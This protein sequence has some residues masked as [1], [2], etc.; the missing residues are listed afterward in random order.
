MPSIPHPLS[1]LLA[2]ILGTGLLGTAGAPRWGASAATEPSAGQEPAPAPAPR[3]VEAVARF[4]RDPLFPDPVALGVMPGRRALYVAQRTGRVSWMELDDEGEAEAVRALLEIDV[5]AASGGEGLLGFVPHPAYVD[6]LKVYV[7]YTPREARRSRVSEFLCARG[8]GAVSERV[9]L[10]VPQ[11]WRNH[12]GGQLEFGPDGLLYIGLGDGGSS[13]DPQRHAQDPGSLLGKILRI[14]I[15]RTQGELAYGIPPDN[16]FVPGP[17]EE[18]SDAV[19]LR[20]EI[21]ALGFSNPRRFSFDPVGGA[22]WFADSGA[23]RFEELG[24]A[25]LGEN[26]GWPIWEGFVMHDRRAP[27]G[28]GALT[29]PCAV[30]PRSLST[31]ILGGLVVRSEQPAALAGRYLF[32]DALSGDLWSV[33]AEAQGRGRPERIG[34]V[35]RPTAFGRGWDGRVLVGTLEGRILTLE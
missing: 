12:N 21:F 31:Q 33:D 26:H 6:T 18:Q 24:T 11:P 19:L 13:G 4:A 1:I 34:R 14:D 28:P 9:L 7:H 29:A 32:A 2:A 17:G 15:E 5:R 27:V 20:P 16:P 25:G 8:G 10:E 23:E 22:L 30:L 35:E 3:A